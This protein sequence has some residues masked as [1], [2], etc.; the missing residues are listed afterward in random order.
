VLGQAHGLP[1]GR[2]RAAAPGLDPNSDAGKQ[3]AQ[4]ASGRQ[5]LSQLGLDAL[6]T[7]N[8]AAQNYFGGQQ[9]IA[10]KEQPAAQTAAAEAGGGEEPAWRCGDRGADDGPA[11]RPE[12]QH[13]QGTLGLNTAKAQADAAQTQ[14]TTTGAHPARQGGREELEGRAGVPAKQAQSTRATALGVPA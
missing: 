9:T 6:N 10:A 14:A 4:A 2:R 1:A 3:A 5:A 8:T 12:L 7:Q 13:R 11:E